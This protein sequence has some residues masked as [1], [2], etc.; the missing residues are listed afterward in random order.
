MNSV[1]K[2]FTRRSIRKYKD[3]PIP[4]EVIKNI[5]EA[6]RLS[7]S[8]VN[9]QPWHFVVVKDQKTKEA[10]SHRYSKFIETSDFTVVGLYL[11]SESLNDRL[12][13]IDVTIALQS[14][15]TAAWL[16]DI[17]SCWIGAFKEDEVKQVL[18]LPDE[19]KIVCLV[20]FGVPDETPAQRPKKALDEIVHYEKW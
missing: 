5:L 19:A 20:S 2:I 17:G 3:E 7:P 10:I 1:E 12:S 8:A 14:M 15:V 18:N 11:P 13:L 9:K 6:G 4:E 16:Q